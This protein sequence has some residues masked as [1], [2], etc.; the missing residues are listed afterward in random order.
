VER[1][2]VC[3]WERSAKRR[4]SRPCVCRRRGGG[5]A[6]GKVGRGGGETKKVYTQ[7]VINICRER[8]RTFS[9][10]SMTLETVTSL[11]RG[12]KSQDLLPL[13]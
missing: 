1:R 7:Y 13:G 8:G 10:P 11:L 12:A 3:R 2:V 4:E 5:E 9:R 6:G